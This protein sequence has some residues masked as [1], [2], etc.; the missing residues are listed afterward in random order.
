MVLETRPAS[1]HAIT[2]LAFG[3][4]SDSLENFCFIILDDTIHQL[5]V[6]FKLKFLSV[7]TKF[8]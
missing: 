8:S 6:D 3:K 5:G 2:T 4:I 1:G 7:L